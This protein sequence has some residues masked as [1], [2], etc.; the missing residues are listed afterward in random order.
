MATHFFL[1]R[2]NNVSL[3]NVECVMN[4]ERKGKNVYHPQTKHIILTPPTKSS[5]SLNK[6][7]VGR[8]RMN[9]LK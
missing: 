2:I 1:R 4:K 7:V 6:S 8:N 9:A 3:A 5:R